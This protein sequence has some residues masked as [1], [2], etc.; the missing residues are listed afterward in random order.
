MFISDGIAEE[1]EHAFIVK[2]FYI[3]FYKNFLLFSFT[4]REN[5]DFE[6]G[7]ARTNNR[8]LFTFC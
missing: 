7:Y 5:L 8:R 6:F 2:Y 4:A 1:E 3:S